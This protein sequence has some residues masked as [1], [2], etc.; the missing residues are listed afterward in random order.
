MNL[1]KIQYSLLKS[2]TSSEIYYWQDNFQ[3][4]LEILYDYEALG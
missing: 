1:V 4:V 2:V 3:V